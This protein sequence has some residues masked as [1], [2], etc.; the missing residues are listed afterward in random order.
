M[1]QKNYRELLAEPVDSQSGIVDASAHAHSPVPL[2]SLFRLGYEQSKTKSRNYAESDS[3]SGRHHESRYQSRDPPGI[4]AGSSHPAACFSQR[5]SNACQLVMMWSGSLT[6][7]GLID[8]C[9]SLENMAGAFAQQVTVGVAVPVCVD[10]GQEP[11]HRLPLSPA[12]GTK[13]PSHILRGLPR[14]T[15][16]PS[17]KPESGLP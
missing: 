10:E 7:V 17:M 15:P 9:R 16:L 4:A 11:V 5:C 8:Q 14:H 3:L 6:W 12:P 13:H 1:E 2:H